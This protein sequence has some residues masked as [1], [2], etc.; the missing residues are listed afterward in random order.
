MSDKNKK[1]TPKAPATPKKPPAKEVKY[2]AEELAAAAENLFEVMPECVI[3]AFTVAGKTE[4]TK[5]EAKQ[6]VE[7][8]LKK[9]VK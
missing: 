7:K 9:E 4:A 5:E 1:Q 8:Y 2:K 6:I 3:A